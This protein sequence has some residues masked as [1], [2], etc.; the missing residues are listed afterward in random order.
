[1]LPDQPACPACPAAAHG[2]VVVMVVVVVVVLLLLLGPRP[3]KLDAC[4][5]MVHCSAAIRH[6]QHPWSC[7]QLTPIWSLVGQPASLQK[8]QHATSASVWHA[9][10]GPGPFSSCT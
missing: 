9:N 6:L 4:P 3:W 7:A 5:G 2:V 1:M 8:E 10:V